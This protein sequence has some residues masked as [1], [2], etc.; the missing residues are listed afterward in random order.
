MRV[1][2]D[3]GTRFVT[4]FRYDVKPD[5]STDAVAEGYDHFTTG[6]GTGDYASFDSVCGKTMVG[7]V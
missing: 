6:F 2:L 3:D 7:F 4:N 5:L 1:E